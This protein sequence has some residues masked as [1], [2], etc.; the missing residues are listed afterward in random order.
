MNK[1]TFQVLA[2]ISIA[3]SATFAAK[4]RVVRF[5]NHV[6]VGYDDNIYNT[7]EKTG[8]GFITDI[9]NLSAKLNFSS[10]SDALFY[11]QPEFQFRFDADPESVVYQDLYAQ[12]NHAISPRAFLTLSDRFR[13]QQKEGQTGAAGGGPSDFKQNYIEN[14]LMGALDY[15]LN[16]VSYM[17]LGGGYEFRTWDD[18]SYGSEGQNNDFT[19]LKANGSYIRQL[20]PNKTEGLLGV[21]YVDHEY[22]GS[23]GGFDSFGLFVG[24]DQNFTPD[25]TGFGRV[26]FSMNSVDG[27]S[28]GSSNDSTTPYLDAGLEVNATARTSVNA[29][30]G[31][32]I[33]RAEN[34]FYN[35]QDRFSI[36]F[37]ARHD[38]TAKINLAASFSYIHSEYKADYS[39]G[40]QPVGDAKDNYVTLALRTSYQVNRNNFLEA[41][42]LFKSRSATGGLNEYD[43]NRI[44][45]AWRLRL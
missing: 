16:D 18:S 25:V 1:R 41:G 14:D 15:T 24:A 33:Y 12:L 37:G 6:R 36:G 27:G 13:Y 39:A 3:S 19:Q 5:Q 38:I 26:G 10:R 43:G 44:D 30:M 7:N 42:Y 20:I 28:T 8:S 17:R 4:E 23:R 45:V 32:S 40:Y 9:V 31:Y 22:E 21:N 11:W 35:A 34:T 2:A 29:S